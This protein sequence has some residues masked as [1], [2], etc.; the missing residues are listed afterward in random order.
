MRD[1]LNTGAIFSLVW[2]CAMADTVTTSLTD[3]H[4]V[5]H[6]KAAFN[7]VSS[8]HCAESLIY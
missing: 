8:Q 2:T 3:K 4:F 5:I 1:I 7:H 6:Y